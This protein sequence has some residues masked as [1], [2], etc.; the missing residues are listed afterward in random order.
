M[1]ERIFGEEP[2]MEG[3]FIVINFFALVGY[4]FLILKLKAIS[5]FSARSNHWHNENPWNLINLVTKL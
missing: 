2:S 5:A 1:V 4:L 3:D